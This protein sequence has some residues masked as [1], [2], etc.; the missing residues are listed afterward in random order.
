MQNLP[1]T[2]VTGPVTDAERTYAL[3][4]LKITQE[5][6]HQSVSG[7]SVS[8]LTFKPGPDRWSIA[9]CVEHIALIEQGILGAVQA[10]MN[11]PADADRR[12]QIRVSDVDVVRAV[13]SRTT[14]LAAPAPF[15]PTNRFGDTEAALRAFDEYRA[16]T[17]AFVQTA[18][19]D[20][21]QHYFRH[22]AL[23]LLDAYQAVLLMAA[24][25]ERHR[26]QI[27]AVKVSPDYPLH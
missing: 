9:E 27:E 17:I 2:P 26:K 8:Q 20:F 12:A 11:A 14:T 19:G 13:R 25:V 16:A 10:G 18:P 4:S 1:A 24:H 7:L 23:G 3:E 21:R 15:V 22:L 5:N 6:L